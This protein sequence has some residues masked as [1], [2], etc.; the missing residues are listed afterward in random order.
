MNKSSMAKAN[1]I[2]TSFP[3]Q[4]NGTDRYQCALCRNNY[5]DETSL[6]AHIAVMHSTGAVNG[7]ASSGANADALN[8]TIPK[9]GGTH[10]SKK[11]NGV[12]EEKRGEERNS[13]TVG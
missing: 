4:I 12:D 2:F 3:F 7:A 13:H 6:E 11:H 1:R 9:T 8:L 5:Q 10:H